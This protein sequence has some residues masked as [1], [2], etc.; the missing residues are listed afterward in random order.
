MGKKLKLALIAML[1]FS[2]ACS[3]SKKSAKSNEPGVEPQP[4]EVI[5]S[6]RI[7]LMYGVRPP[8]QVET[9]PE[10]EEPQTEEPQTEAKAEAKQETEPAAVQQ[11][12][13]PSEVIEIPRTVVMY[14]VKPPYPVAVKDSVV[15]D[16]VLQNNAVETDPQAEE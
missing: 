12:E 15:K 9:E 16:K 8:L 14:G 2:T 6:P 4:S 10:T 13:Q 1:G 11:T 7:M 3:T 5:E